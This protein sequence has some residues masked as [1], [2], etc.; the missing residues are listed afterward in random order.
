MQRFRVRAEFR[1][2]DAGSP[3]VLAGVIV[4]HGFWPAEPGVEEV[5][6]RLP[7]PGLVGWADLPSPV[8]APDA[9]TAA[10]IGLAAARAAWPERVR[11]RVPHA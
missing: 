10:G 11:R 5:R 3:W 2:L 4:R 9:E 8:L 6:R 1:R 7:A